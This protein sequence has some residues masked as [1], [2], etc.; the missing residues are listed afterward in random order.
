MK[1]VDGIDFIIII[2]LDMTLHL[3]QVRH[4]IT[5]FHCNVRLRHGIAQLAVA[6]KLQLRDKVNDTLPK[7]S[8]T[9]IREHF[10]ILELEEL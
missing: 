8:F 9:Y 5:E 4:L 3:V 7:H 10:T 2:N 6:A 1:S